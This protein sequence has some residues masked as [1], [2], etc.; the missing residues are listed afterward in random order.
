MD[1]F[2]WTCPY[3]GDHT[4]ITDPNTDSGFTQ[5]LAERSEHGKIGLKYTAITCPNIQCRKLSLAVELRTWSWKGQNRSIG[6][7][8]EKWKL[9]PRS[10]AMPQPDYIPDPIR[11]DYEEAC[12][13]INDSPKASATLF[14]R[15]LQGMVRD[16]WSLPKSKRGNLKQELDS[17]SEDV[18]PD[19]WQAIDSVRSV[20]NIGAHMEKDINVIVDVDPEEAGLL[21]ELIE[22]L[23]A[24]WYV[25]RHKRKER[26]AAAILL[27][28]KKQEERKGVIDNAE[29]D[30]NA[31]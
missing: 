7:L 11:Q 17:I 8:I 19:V 15:C 16:Y 25:Q 10:G 22:M 28:N 12:L 14:R 6:V 5:V 9:L 24:D 21:K 2:H 4:T 20:G 26:T 1:A 27:A 3:C 23:F 29:S 18:D 13:I 30:D 31:E